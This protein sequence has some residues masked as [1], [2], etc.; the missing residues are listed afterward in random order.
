MN[1]E[2][3][4]QNMGS[5]AV[6]PVEASYDIVAVQAQLK[7]KA[8]DPAKLEK[9]TSEIDIS[10]TATIVA[11][12][13]DAAEGIARCSD[14]VLQSVE[15]ERI[16]QT[17]ALMQNLTAI[18]DK[19]DPKELTDEKR[20]LAKIF[21]KAKAHL[22]KILEKYNT[23][24][25]EVEKIAVELRKFETQ[26]GKSN[27]ALELLFQENIS[28]FQSLEDYIIAGED[29]VRQIDDHR[30]KV[31]S[32]FDQTQDATLQFQIQSLTLAKDML[33]QRVHDLRVAENVAI[34]TIPMLKSMQYTNFN[35][36]RKI[37]SAFIITLPV[38]KQALA[39]AVLLK[40]QKMQSEALAALDEKTNEMLIKNAQNT[41]NQTIMAERLAS[42]SSI[43][44]ETLEQT[45]KTIM[46]GIAETRKIHDEAAKRRIDEK[47][48]LEQMKQDMTTKNFLL[49]DSGGNND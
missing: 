8:T 48:R 6:E 38:F 23:M 11:F 25:M 39:Q 1:L 3:S 47:L 16:N 17:S 28:F 20:G 22:Q 30:T 27:Q 31:Q 18:M 9:L 7:K 40:T 24:G 10:N 12:G 21:S 35:L 46:D 4:L 36:A 33:E 37:N 44:I 45:Y 19:F 14:S 32:Q 29:G 15:M 5:T 41:M 34:Q 13:K 26:I 49:T 42:G 2:Q 43:K